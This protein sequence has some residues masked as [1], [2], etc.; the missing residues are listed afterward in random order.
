MTEWRWALVSAT[1]GAVIAVGLFWLTGQPHLGRH[2]LPATQWVT[3]APMP[4]PAVTTG[5]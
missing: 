4:Q 1:A 3:P 5:N 2:Q